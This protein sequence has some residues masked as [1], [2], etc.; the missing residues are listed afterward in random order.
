MSPACTL[1]LALIV[2]LLLAPGVASAAVT[3]VD[4]TP[5]RILPLHRGAPALPVLVGNSYGSRPAAGACR[6]AVA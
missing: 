5:P 1:I 4:L 6:A 2:A 3:P